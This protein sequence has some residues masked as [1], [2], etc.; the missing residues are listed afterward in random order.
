MVRLLASLDVVGVTDS[1][2]STGLFTP[3]Q[4]KKGNY[5]ILLNLPEAA[6]VI[7]GAG[8]SL[9]RDNLETVLA[10]ELGHFIA[11]VFHDPTHDEDKIK[12]AWDAED[13]KLLVPTEIK[14]WDLAEVIKPNL[15]KTI[16]EYA[17]KSYKGELS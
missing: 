17:L 6:S 12:K 15:N 8:E 9:T 1:S 14:A 13:G 3:E 10:H 2:T 11:N 5:A 7:V 4:T 16:R